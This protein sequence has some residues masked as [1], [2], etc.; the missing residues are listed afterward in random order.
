ALQES[1]DRIKAAVANAGEQWPRS[2]VVLALSPA[3]L[4]K[5]G[6]L[7]DLALACAVLNAQ[8]RLPGDRLRAA[9]LLGELALAGRVRSVRGVLPAVLA[10]REAG[11]RTVVVPAGN[12]GEAASVRGVAVYG[13]AHLAEL[14]AWMRGRVSLAPPGPVPTAD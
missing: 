11:W 7:H 6:S 3:T 8:G 9:V 2:R 10:A 12:L 5:V 13:T 1:R 4:H 14:V